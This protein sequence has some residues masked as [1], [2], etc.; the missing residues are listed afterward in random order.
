MAEQAR[1]AL[2]TGAADGIGW[3]MA[4]VLQPVAIRVV[5]ADLRKDAAEARVAELGQG[6]CAAAAR[7]GV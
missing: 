4:R 5:I 6:H 1:S 7:C 2:I 3:A